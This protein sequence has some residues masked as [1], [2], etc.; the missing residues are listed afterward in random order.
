MAVFIKK[1][2]VGVISENH[3]EKLTV[4]VISENDCGLCNSHKLQAV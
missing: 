2:T 4:G 3:C 1:L